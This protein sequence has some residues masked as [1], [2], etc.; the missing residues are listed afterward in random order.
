[1]LTAMGHTPIIVANGQEAVLALEKETFDL[2]LMDMKMP[3]MDGYTATQTIRNS[4]SVK[5]PKIPIIALTANAMKGDREICLEKG[6]DGYAAKPLQKKE[7]TQA[8]QEVI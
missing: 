8:I 5:N 6:M 1:M 4:S 7:L 2:V 3:I